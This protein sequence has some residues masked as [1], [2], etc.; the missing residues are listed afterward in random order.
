MK[1]YFSHLLN[2]KTI[3]AVML[4]IF[5]MFLLGGCEGKSD[6]EITTLKV[7]VTMYDEYDPFTTA[8]ANSISEKLKVF[9]QEQN[10]N[11]ICDVVYSNKS[12][13]QQNDQVENF[14][15][16][17]YDVVC[18]N[19]VDRTDAMQIIDKAKSNDIPVIFFNRELVEEDL[20]RFDKLYYVGA[21]PEES[22][23]YQAEIIVDI[24][25]DPARFS[26]CDFSND[27]VIQYVMLEGE[28]GHQD[29]MVR[30]KVS[31]EEIQNAGFKLEKISDK[32]A[33]WNR[34]Q[35]ETKMLSILEGHP[36]QIELVIANDDN[37]ALGALDA[38]EDFGVP[39]LPL[40]VGVNGEKEVIDDI[41]N[42]QIAGTVYNNGYQMGEIIAKMAISLGTQDKIP[43][44]ITLE[45]GKYVFAPYEKIDKDNAKDYLDKAIY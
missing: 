33:N 25:S 24:L 41:I 1:K 19:L 5:A 16:K 42:G 36:W 6:T 8:I 38:L 32:I 2:K 14:I 9:A 21:A 3:I 13:L 22:G 20:E 30:T 45:K 10:L 23:R 11:I 26:Q 31:V 12:Q 35:A 27:G 43:E 4:L 28:A 37:I 15:D 39:E 44:D 40:I 7:G 18:V 29:A 34:E 17:G